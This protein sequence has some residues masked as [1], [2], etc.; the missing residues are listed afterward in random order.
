ME[1]KKDSVS[2]RNFLKGSAASA[3]SVAAASLLG[4]G[5][6]RAEEAAEQLYTPG[7]Y[8]ATAMGIGEVTV[9][10]TFDETSI[11]E[12]V[13][14]VSNESEDI[15]QLYGTTLQEALMEAQS[16]EI[17]GVSGA[18]VTSDA[19]KE[20]A[21]NC[22]AQALGVDMTAAED[23]A[24]D[25]EESA[26]GSEPSF[27]T[28]PDP[29]DDSQISEEV[30]A[31]VVIVGCGVAGLCAARSAAEEGVSVVVIEKGTSY[32]YRSGQYGIIGA[33]F[34]ND[35][36]IETDGNAVVGN[37][38]KEM[39]YRPD[40]RLWN[41]WKE[42]VGAVFDWFVEPAGDNLDIIDRTATEYD[43][44]KIT[45]CGL[46]YPAPE[47]FDP[48]EEYSPTYPEATWAFI[49][50][51]GGILELNYQKALENGAEFYFSTWARQLIRPDNEGRVQGVIGQDIDG[52]YIKFTANKGAIM[53]AG[54]YG[55]N[56]EMVK[57][58]CGGRT[59][60]GFFGSVDANG[61]TTNIGEGQQMGIWIGAHMEDGPHA[62]MTHTLGG[63]L[64]VDPFFMANTDGKRFCN[65]DVAGQQL[66]SQLYRQ[67][68]EYAWYIFDDNYPDQ[69]GLMGASHGSV[70]HIVD[71]SENPHLDGAGMTI[72]RTSMSSRE[73][74]EESAIKADT[75]EELVTMLDLSEEAQ[76]N[77]LASIEKYNQYCEDGYDAEFNKTPSRLF[78]IKTAPFYASKVSAGQ[79]LVCLGGLTVDPETL[80]VLDD[81]FNPIEG[82]YAAGNNMGGRILQDYPVTI[83][84]VSHSTC[85]TFGYMT[86]KNAA[87][88]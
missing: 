54:D 62:P 30:N 80:Q 48:A 83:G 87:N 60:S 45:L 79:M 46:H 85:M 36:G 69:V 23:T 39:G 86:G 9:S 37:L 40:Q 5:V 73:E 28:A 24:A 7:T 18:T 34:Q 66:S 74:V 14:D 67:K 78:P 47:A 27:L 49:P 84:G 50:D 55:S 31:D 20:A 77:L 71:E 10:I 56:E 35:L 6:I 21:A 8:T 59:Y 15:G 13:V 32:N 22:I 75:L 11:T 57:Y 44:S 41:Q 25:T 53:A 63:A 64:G 3:F 2:R 68:G 16:A 42:N 58:Y 29:I 1:K 61:D 12:V 4:G 33:S 38:M 70:N 51:Q 52:N 65:E 43:S 17:D 81:D 88:A 76:E 26:S 19:V 72:G 82:L